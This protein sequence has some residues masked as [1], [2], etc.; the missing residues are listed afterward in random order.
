M[1]HDKLTNI[2]LGVLQELVWSVIDTLQT[3]GVDTADNPDFI[4]YS[5]LYGKLGGTPPAPS[6]PKISET[7]RQ[8]SMTLADDL[9]DIA[10]NRG[11]QDE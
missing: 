5:N 2:E 8:S 1:S 7:A 3:D 11:T 4:A 10:R 6:E 9:I